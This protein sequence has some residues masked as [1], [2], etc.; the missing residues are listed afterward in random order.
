M[1]V[2]RCEFRRSHRDDAYGACI[3]PV[4]LLRASAPSTSTGRASVPQRT[5]SDF[6]Q[7]PIRASAWENAGD[8]SAWL[9]RQAGVGRRPP[10]LLYPARSSRSASG[11]GL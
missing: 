11:L 8:V 4:L 5:L 2:R 10:A 6:A 7:T 1:A 3:R 9:V